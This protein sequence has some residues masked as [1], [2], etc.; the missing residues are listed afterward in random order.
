MQTLIQCNRFA[1]LLRTPSGTLSRWSWPPQKPQRP[2]VLSIFGSF[3]STLM[4]TQGSPL[5]KPILCAT[6]AG[7]VSAHPLPLPLAPP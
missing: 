3:S 2:C 1:V 4:G 7:T 5:C 6:P